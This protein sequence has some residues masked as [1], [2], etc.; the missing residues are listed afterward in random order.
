M[1]ILSIFKSNFDRF[2]TDPLYLR[3]ISIQLW[4]NPTALYFLQQAP[5][6]LDSL[7]S[8]CEFHFA[9][10]FPA[11]FPSKTH[12]QQF[13]SLHIKIGNVLE[14]YQFFSTILYLILHNNVTRNIL[15]CQLATSL[16]Y[17]RI[18]VNS[19]ACN[20]I[21]WLEIFVLNWE[22]FKKALSL[23]RKVSKLKSTL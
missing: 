11:K 3:H 21:K 17:T 23:T 19:F 10:Y 22:I 12:W 13:S 14:C 2:M 15:I 6:P 20:T 9:S 5:E 7:K 4:I 1:K 18:S 8:L 16:K